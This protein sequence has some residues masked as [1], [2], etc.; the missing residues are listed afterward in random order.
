MGVS[1]NWS[2]PQVQEEVDADEGESSPPPRKWQ[3][4]KKRASN[5]PKKPKKFGWIAGVLVS[6]LVRLCS[7]HDE[8]YMSGELSP[9]HTVCS[10]GWLQYFK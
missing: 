8:S 10:S 6:A 7:L 1:G 2:H 4:W 3:F 9:A 5:K